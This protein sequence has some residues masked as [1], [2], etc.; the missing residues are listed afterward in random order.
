MD[1]P[2]LASK[3]D[4]RAVQVPATSRIPV[5]AISTLIIVAMALYV[6]MATLTDWHAFG[7]ATSSISATL[8]IEVVGLSLL[9]YLARFI[10]WHHFIRALEHRIPVTRNLEIYLSGFALTLTPGKAG[11]TIRTIYL[12]PYGV[13]YPESIGALIAE[14]LLDLMA[15]ALLACLAVLMF[16]QHL[17]WLSGAVSLCL[18]LVFLFRSRLISLVTARLAVSA[19]G[20]DVSNGINIVSFLLSG[21]RLTVA[22]PFS[23]LAWSAQGFSLYLIVGSLGYDLSV[24]SGISIYCLSILAGAA[25]FIPGGLGATEAAIAVLLS[26]A[27]VNQAD[28]VTASLVSRGLTL[29]LAVGIGV[30]GMCRVAL[31]AG[32]KKWEKPNTQ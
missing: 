19:L 12:A 16:P 20:G 23:F 25:S 9:S 24:F 4:G 21:S 8:W 27:G 26:A 17:L 29:W 6:A 7:R 15:V 22:L 14:R 5:R 28:A 31:M 18:A 3:L 30:G 11:E 32:S 10:R 1:E 13:R 2:A